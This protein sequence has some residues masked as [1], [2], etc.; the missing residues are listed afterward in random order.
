MANQAA[1]QLACARGDTLVADADA[2]VLT[3]E[4]GGPAALAGA[5]VRPLPGSAGRLDLEA[6]AAALAAAPDALRSRVGLVV[7]ENTH[8]RAGGVALPAAYTE[9]VAALAAPHGVAVHLDGARLWNA[10][11]ALGCPPAALTRPVTTVAVSLNKGLGAPLGAVLAGPRA[12]IA[13]ALR[14]RQRLGGGIRPAGFLAAAALVAL[15]TMPERLAEDHARA[16]AL[17]TALAGLGLAASAA[18]NIVLVDT[19]PL[20]ADAAAVAAALAR[21]GVL[22][23]PFGAARIR[24]VVHNAVAADDIAAVTAAFGRAQAELW[25]APTGAA[26]A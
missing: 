14:I 13:E 2:H 23:L 22:V 24:L 21:H 15:D 6:L 25:R 26:P 9:R 5:M 4:A 20:G 16:A 8:N 19:K 7:L 17:A 1:I 12:A 18:T 10:A 11:V 3:S